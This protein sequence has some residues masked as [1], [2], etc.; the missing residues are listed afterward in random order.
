[1]PCPARRLLRPIRMRQLNTWSTEPNGAHPPLSGGVSS[2][3]A[4]PLSSAGR[5][6]RPAESAPDVRPRRGPLLGVSDPTADRPRTETASSRIGRWRDLLQDASPADGRYAYADGGFHAAVTG[7]P[8]RKTP[9]LGAV[10]AIRGQLCRFTN[11]LAAAW[12]SGDASVPLVA[13]ARRRRKQRVVEQSRRQA[14][15]VDSRDESTCA[16]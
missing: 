7:K 10:P 14:R 11:G 15:T 6:E 13:A 3:G 2:S 5:L 4:T 1:M 16:V 9:F 12:G 8:T